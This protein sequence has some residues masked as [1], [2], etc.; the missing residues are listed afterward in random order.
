MA[1]ASSKSEFRPTGPVVQAK[2]PEAMRGYVVHLARPKQRAEGVAVVHLNRQAGEAF[3]RKV[4]A[5]LQRESL[6]D[7]VVSIGRPG[8]LRLIDLVCTPP[9]AERV[10]AMPEV[11]DVIEADTPMT[12]TRR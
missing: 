8:S 4:E 10:R 6:K 2:P 1:G 11:E 5:L 9:V 12:L 7:Q 3:R